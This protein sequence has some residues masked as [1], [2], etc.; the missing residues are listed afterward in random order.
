MTDA[1]IRWSVPRIAHVARVSALSGITL[2]R[3]ETMKSDIP[4]RVTV[5]PRQDIPVTIQI[6]PIPDGRGGY[7]V[8]ELFGADKVY[9]AVGWS[10]LTVYRTDEFITFAI[11]SSIQHVLELPEREGDGDATDRDTI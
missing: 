9:R 10:T 5:R 1:T 3:P 7:G 8:L 11:D 2:E 4:D 6:H